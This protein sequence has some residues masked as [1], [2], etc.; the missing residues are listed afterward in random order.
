MV[1]CLKLLLVL[2]VVRE[3]S[4]HMY[5]LD[6]LRQTTC[7][8]VHEARYVHRELNQPILFIHVGYLGISSKS[9]AV[10]RQESICPCRAYA[11]LS[12]HCNYAACLQYSDGS[13]GMLRTVLTVVV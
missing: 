1:Y 9:I 13:R 5:L 2:T 6:I 8:Y 7:T 11:V 12:G 4:M 10:S 3:F